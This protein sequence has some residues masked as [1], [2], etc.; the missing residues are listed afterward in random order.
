MPVVVLDTETSGLP[1]EPRASVVEIGAIS[2]SDNGEYLGA[3]SSLVK[4]LHP[5]GEWSKVAME[6]NCVPEKLLGIAPSANDA[7]LAFVHWMGLFKPVKS[8]LAYN[9]A[10]DRAMMIRS[11]P[12]AEYLPWGPCLMQAARKALGGKGHLKL[13]VAAKELGIEV[14]G[15]AHRALADAKTAAKV[16]KA[17]RVKEIA[18]GVADA[19]EA[20]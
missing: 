13:V 6:I 5:L 12:Q 1:N 15:T 2:L 3:F 20:D 7:W 8:V 16:W 10:F 17:L 9:V 4:P 11:W 19:K 14:D 18:N